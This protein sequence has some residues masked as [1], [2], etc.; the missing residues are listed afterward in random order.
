MNNGLDVEHLKQAYDPY[1]T[2]YKENFCNGTQKSKIDSQKIPQKKS[3]K[4]TSTKT[5]SNFQN[6][7]KTID[8]KVSFE[9]TTES[10]KRFAE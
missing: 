5:N 1:S 9:Q 6:G 8:K 2:V 3:L 4:E 7:T 10:G